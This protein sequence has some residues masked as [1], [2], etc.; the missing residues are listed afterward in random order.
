MLKLSGVQPAE[1]EALAVWPAMFLH[2]IHS[3]KSLEVDRL[4]LE[5]YDSD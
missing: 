3:L 1:E 2:V 5:A 4:T